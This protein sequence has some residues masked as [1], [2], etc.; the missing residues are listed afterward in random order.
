MALDWL[1]IA[2]LDTLE[3]LGGF[4]KWAGRLGSGDRDLG[5]ASV[6]A[7]AELRHG[8]AVTDDREATRVARRHGA[9]VHGTIWLLATACRLEKLTL[10]AAGNVMEALRTEGARLPCTGTEFEAFAR[11]HQLLPPKPG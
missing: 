9:D 7:A 1:Q 6:L 2:S 4:V 8:I 5:E 10:V 3:E 11:R